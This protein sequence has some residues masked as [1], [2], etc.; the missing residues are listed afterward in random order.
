MA[1]RDIQKLIAATYISCLL[2]IILWSYGYH[3]TEDAAPAGGVR[4][5]RHFI[6]FGLFKGEETGRRE[7]RYPAVLDTTQL[8]PGD[9]I[10]C[11]NPKGIYGHWS[12]VTMFMG[13]DQVIMQNITQGISLGPADELD[14]YDE[15]LVLRPQVS[16]L[17]REDAARMAA[18][19]VGGVFNLTAH[20]MDFS[21]WTCAKSVWWAY[22]QL[23]IEISDMRFWITPDALANFHADIV[24]HDFGVR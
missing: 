6:Y 12:H 4:F 7:C 8:R 19:T 17:I 2:V 23:G 24:E 22:R 13:K 14:G 1:M 18:R 11:R 20:R 16:A 21:Q 15:I 5:A 9:V 10:L 3:G